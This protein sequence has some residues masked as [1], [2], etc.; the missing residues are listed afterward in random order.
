LGRIWLGL[1]HVTAWALWAAVGTTG[2]AVPE[3]VGALVAV[4]WVLTTAGQA[5]TR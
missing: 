1:V 4:V 2:I 3:T 5:W